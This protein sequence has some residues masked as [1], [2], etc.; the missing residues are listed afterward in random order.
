MKNKLLPLSLL[1]IFYAINI[2]SQVINIE[3]IK[4]SSQGKCIQEKHN[5]IFNDDTYARKDLYDN[6][7]ITG[8]SKIT[9]TGYNDNGIYWET[10]SPKFYLKKYGIDEFRKVYQYGIKVFY[11]KRGGNA[12]YVFEIDNE[13]RNDKGKYFIT[14][15]GAEKICN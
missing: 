11:D 15:I 9:S 8:P 5:I 4:P 7:V 13:N 10:R 6:K 3:Y 14:S 12:L 1:L 2:N